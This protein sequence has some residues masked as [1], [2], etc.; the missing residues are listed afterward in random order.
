MPLSQRSFDLGVLRPAVERYINRE[1]P[2]PADIGALRAYLRQW[3]MHPGWDKNPFG[4]AES[5]KALREGIDRLHTRADVDEWSRLAED[6]GV[7]PW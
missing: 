1:P 2:L 3:I 7:D 6:F 5:L 4:G